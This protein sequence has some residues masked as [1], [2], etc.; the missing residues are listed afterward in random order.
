MESRKGDRNE[1]TMDAA[2]TLSS[3]VGTLRNL[4]ASPVQILDTGGSGTQ[5]VAMACG[6]ARV[7]S[8]AVS[9]VVG[10]LHFANSG[11]FLLI[12]WST[13]SLPIPDILTSLMTRSHSF[14]RLVRPSI[15]LCSGDCVHHLVKGA[16]EDLI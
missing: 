13:S 12:C 6:K 8:L 9:P 11:C 5:S 2:F 16:L 4:F 10:M 15:A 7:E 1:R 14:L 3:F